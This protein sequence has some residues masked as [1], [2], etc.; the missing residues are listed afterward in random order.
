MTVYPDGF[1]AKLETYLWTS[2]CGETGINDVNGA[3]D[4]Y[5]VFHEY[6]HGM[7]LRLVTDS[8]G[9]GALNDAQPG[10]MGEAWSDWYAEDYLVAGGFQSD[11]AAPGELRA[12][13]YLGAAD[14]RTQPFDCPVAPPGGPCP[15]TGGA[16]PGGYTYADFGRIVG[17]PEVHADGEIWAETL[18][19]L[20]RALVAKHPADGVTR[21]R[22][23]ITDGMRLSPPE[24]SFLEGRDA[25]LKSD[26]ARGYGDRDLIWAVFAARGMGLNATTTGGTDTAPVAGFAAPPPQPVAPPGGNVSPPRDTAAPRVSGFGVTNRLFRVGSSRTPRS[27]ARRVGV[28]TRFRFRLSE[29]AG[30][31]IVL[32]RALAGR[33]VKGSCRRPTRALRRR[34]RCTR[35]VSA[36][37]L[38][39]SGQL[40]GAAWVRFSGRLGSRALARGGY[41][42]VL[43][44]RDA[45][46]NRSR[47]VSTRFTIVR[48]RRSAGA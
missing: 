28:G 20:R 38:V 36:G 2:A 7:S 18:W 21:A 1:P 27:A 37:R 4:P 19:D 26:V 15:G 8:A 39:R 12:G 10:A 13:P 24:P 32:S 44:A 48:P 14:L 40:P 41:R 46:G 16:G 5:V 23:L 22:A 33:R 42:A 45:A 43:T 17:E 3:D 9:V 29:R 47:A 35:W 25:I 6:T 11:T 34:A 30:V 31:T